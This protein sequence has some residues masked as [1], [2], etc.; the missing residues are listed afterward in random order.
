ML[1][2]HEKGQKR[3]QS[4]PHKA[5]KNLLHPKCYCSLKVDQETLDQH[6]S[7]TLFDETYNIP[8]DNL[9][10]LPP[11][12]PLVKKFNTSSFSYDNFLAILAAHRNTSAPVLNGIPYKVYKKCLKT[13]KFLFKIVQACYKRCQ[14]PTQWQSAQE[15]YI[16][17][18]STPCDTNILDFRPIALLNVEVKLFLV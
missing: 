16:A 8:L 11:E 13:S 3:V 10:A 7:F 12:S 2:A 15:I 9:E 4:N 14:I 6:K 5:G 1:L 17:K 18:V